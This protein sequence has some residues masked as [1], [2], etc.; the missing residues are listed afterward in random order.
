MNPEEGELRPQLLD[1]F[2]LHISIQELLNEEQR[3][4]IVKNNLWFGEAP[5]DFINNYKNQL[6]KKYIEGYNNIYLELFKKIKV[7]AI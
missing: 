1:R 6:P 2:S 4:E 7:A 5:L 3:V